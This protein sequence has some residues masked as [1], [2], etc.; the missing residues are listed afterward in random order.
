MTIDSTHGAKPVS[1]MMLL[2]R[3]GQLNLAPGFQRKSIWTLSDRRKLIQSIV[4]GYPLPNIFLY[5][6]YKGG[7]VIYDVIDGKQR[8]ESIF[9][10]LGAGKF[11]PQTFAARLRDIGEWGTDWWT[12][13]E[14]KSYQRDSPAVARVRDS[15]E[16]FRL[17]TVEVTGELADIAD[18]FVCINSTGKSLTSGEKR[19]AKYLDSR[20]LKEANTLVKRHEHWLLG[21]KIL[22]AGEIARMKGTE[23]YAELLMSIHL[24]GIMD[25]KASLD[26]A[27]G[28]GD[29]AP[30]EL[31]RTVRELVQTTALIRKMFP[32]MGETRFRNTAEYYSLF[33]LVWEMR[34]ARFILDDKK[35]NRHAFE[36]LRRL[37]K[38]VGE[39]R[40][41]HRRVEPTRENPPYDRYLLTV[42]GDTDSRATRERRE[43]ILKGM[44]WSLYARKDDQ[45]IFSPEQRLILWNSDAQRKC[46]NP[47]CGKTLDW[48]NFTVD[49]ILPHAKG[50]RTRLANAQL[51]C[52][53]C[54]SRK[55]AKRAR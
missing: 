38:E 18:L 27:I 7:K 42:Q 51:M 33:L 10:F 47:K 35:R 14:I 46:A 29:L 34:K 43:R 22:S 19:H 55:G 37:T 11:A 53:S 39:L 26:R 5:R 49:H 52:G 41:S 17:Q 31:A 21:E 44:L 2:L 8:L 4:A 48:N 1:D 20:L 28:R 23:L 32:K 54:N 24:G 40:E 3:A 6:R 13:A 16:N 50:G 30:R 12:W 45:R 9:M 36:M 25:K 15:V